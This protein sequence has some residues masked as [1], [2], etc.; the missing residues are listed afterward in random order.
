MGRCGVNETII[1]DLFDISNLLVCFLAL[2]VHSNLSL[3]TVDG[4]SGATVAWRHP[5][6]LCKPRFSRKNVV[7]R[8]KYTFPS[9]SKP[10]NWLTSTFN[11][12]W[13]TFIFRPLTLFWLPYLGP[14]YDFGD[15]GSKI[16]PP[17]WPLR[18][19]GV[20]QNFRACGGQ[21]KHHF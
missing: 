5:L 14:L 12:F 15:G 7:F 6:I 13:T 4:C 20:I 2:P 21:K 9:N 17:P 19:G 11:E 18:L 1:T 3:V 10:K 8:G 16:T